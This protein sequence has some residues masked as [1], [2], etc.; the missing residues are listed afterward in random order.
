MFDEPEQRIQPEL[1]EVKRIVRETSQEKARSTWLSLTPRTLQGNSKRLGCY[2]GLIS[3]TEHLNQ[4][5]C[6]INKVVYL[7][8]SVFGQGGLVLLLRKGG[9]RIVHVR[10]VV[11]VPLELATV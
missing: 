7:Q 5:G 11:Y 2:V 6:H 8:I 1:P 10:K 3:N 9:F 4:I